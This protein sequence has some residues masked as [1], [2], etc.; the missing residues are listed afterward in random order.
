MLSLPKST[1]FNKHIPKKKFYEQLEV[2]PEIKRVFVDQIK[3]IIWRNKIAPS[4]VNIAEGGKVTEI[5]VFE[6]QLTAQ[7]LDEKIL[8][9]IDQGIPYP[10]VFVLH[11][12]KQIQIWLAFKE[13]QNAVGS[14]YKVV[15]YY[16]TD[17]LPEDSYTL[18]LKGLTID[19]VYENLV[20]EI[21]GTELTHNEDESLKESIIKTDDLNS[22]KK[23]IEKLQAKMRKEKQFNKKVKL[24]DELRSLKEELRTLEYGKNEDGVS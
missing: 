15:T 4:T 10:I 16:H 11:H 14:I 23:R 12:E 21:A 17:W 24:N 22:L 18:D 13:A 3:N 7:S 19:Q 2:T 9:Q 5:E 8:R 20:R 6:V 1:E